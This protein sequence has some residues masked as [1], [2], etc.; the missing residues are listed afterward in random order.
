MIRPRLLASALVVT[1]TTLLLAGCFFGAPAAP[2][3]GGTEGNGQSGQTDGTETEPGN[4]MLQGVPATFPS[5]VPLIAGDVPIGVDLGTGWTVVVKVADV[6]ASY[7]E[8]SALLTGAG[9]DVLVENSSPEG[10]FGAFENA[11]YQVQV[12]GGDTP[13]YGVTI[14]YLV[15]KKD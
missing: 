15:V 3:G 7:A 5:E 13:D 4:E 10:S 12:T 2:T 14:S 9:F 8:A 1:A 6:Q 11:T